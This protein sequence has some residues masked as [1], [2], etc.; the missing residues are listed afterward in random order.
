MAQGEQTGSEI[1]TN[2][3]FAT[4]ISSWT[5]GMLGAATAA[6]WDA[7]GKLA[8][9]RATGANYSFATQTLSLTVGKLYSIT[10]TATTQVGCEIGSVIFPTAGDMLTGVTANNATRTFFFTATAATAYLTFFESTQSATGTVD[11]V[12]VKEIVETTLTLTSNWTRVNTPAATITN[13]SIIIKLAT[14]G[15]AIDVQVVQN[16]AGGVVTSPIPTAGASVTR[17]AD[18]VS[19]ANTLWPNQDAAMAYYAKYVANFVDDALALQYC[20]FENANASN[21][22][23]RLQSTTQTS[24][25]GRSLFSVRDSVGGT[26]NVESSTD[27]LVP[28]G[29]EFEVRATYDASGQAHSIN[30]AAVIIGAVPATLPT[31][32]TLYLGSGGPFALSHINGP[33]E[34]FAAAPRRVVNGDLP[35]W[36]AA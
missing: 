21:E 9:S 27:N 31:C 22:Y 29:A 23:V 10:F 20:V 30:G 12:S 32:N 13:P 25:T 19:I 34:I 28:S 7:T 33:L 8:I 11:N 16:E 24:R 5:P 36:L 1:V 14:S 4:D 6:T 18:I 17:L 35:T 15:D 26:V 2:G 3:D